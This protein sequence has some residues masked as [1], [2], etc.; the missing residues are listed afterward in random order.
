MGKSVQQKLG[1]TNVG[2]VDCYEPTTMTTDT[3]TTQT[4]TTTLPEL[5][6]DNTYLTLDEQTR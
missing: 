2:Q 5:C 3:P 1:H 4:L 6:N